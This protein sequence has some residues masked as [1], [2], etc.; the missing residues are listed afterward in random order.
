MVISG[1][2]FTPSGSRSA[3]VWPWIR[4]GVGAGLADHLDEFQ[5]VEDRHLPVEKHDVGVAL[6]EAFEATGAI[7]SFDHIAG[8]KAVQERPQDPAHMKVV[9]DNEK[10]ELVEIDV[11]HAKVW[12]AGFCSPPR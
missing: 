8:A 6:A 1:G 2:R 5:A 11:D 4:I 12:Q 7:L 10:P 9:V 3:V